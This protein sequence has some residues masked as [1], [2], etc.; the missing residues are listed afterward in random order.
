MGYSPK[1][2]VG[3]CD[4]LPDQTPISNLSLSFLNPISQEIISIKNRVFFQKVIADLG[5]QTTAYYTLW[6]ELIPYI[7]IAYRKES[8]S[9]PNPIL[10]QI[11]SNYADIKCLNHK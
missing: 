1:I 10:L 8:P 5:A 11:K 2:G 3:G 4:A 7:Y 6:S 9:S